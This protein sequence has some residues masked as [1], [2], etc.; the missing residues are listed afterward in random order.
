MKKFLFLFAS[1]IIGYMI[2]QRRTMIMN[3]QALQNILVAVLKELPIF[4]TA[5]NQP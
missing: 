1:G 5:Q 3:N 2:F 4:K